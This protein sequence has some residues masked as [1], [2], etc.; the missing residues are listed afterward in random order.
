M[1]LWLALGNST[2]SSVICKHYPLCWKPLRLVIDYLL[3]AVT[4]LK[5]HRLSASSV[6]VVYLRHACLRL[7]RSEGQGPWVISALSFLSE[8]LK[9][10][11]GDQGIIQRARLDTMHNRALPRMIR[12]RILWWCISWP[13]RMNGL[14][15]G[16]QKPI[17]SAF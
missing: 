12:V 2:G 10:A 7:S 11:R 4:S 17:S 16:L 8:Y 1:I 9:W 14:P 5:S 6:S 3:E 15:R 13:S